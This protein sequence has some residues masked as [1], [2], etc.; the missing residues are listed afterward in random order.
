MT[1]IQPA[2][3]CFRWRSPTTFVSIRFIAVTT[4]FNIY[5]ARNN[6]W[7]LF[8]VMNRQGN[9]HTSLVF[10]RVI[11]RLKQ[12]NW[13]DYHGYP[14]YWCFQI[15]NQQLRF[16][17][18]INIMPKMLE[19]FIIL[20]QQNYHVSLSTLTRN[21]HI[22]VEGLFFDWWLKVQIAYGGKESP[23]NLCIFTCISLC[24]RKKNDRHFRRS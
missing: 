16:A 11:E 8:L 17:T 21:A 4:V 1:V 10:T 24:S 22:L 13:N 23:L 14:A 9:D 19:P 2:N 3:R 15:C 20:Q 12:W 7:C 5:F 18:E 6:I